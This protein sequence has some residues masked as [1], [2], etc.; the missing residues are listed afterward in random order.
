MLRSGKS[1][2]AQIA[3]AYFKA[4]LRVRKWATGTHSDI[5]VVCKPSYRNGQVELHIQ[6][7]NKATWVCKY[8]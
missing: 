5:N 4:C 3:K 6:Y 1:P 8:H 7:G 2:V